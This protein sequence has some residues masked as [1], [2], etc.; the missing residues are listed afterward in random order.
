M[1]R[2]FSLSQAASALS[3][4]AL[5]LCAS[6]AQTDDDLKALVERG[7]FSAAFA[8]AVK[9]AEAGSVYAESTLG[10]LYLTGNGTSKNYDEAQ[11]WLTKAASAGDAK[12]QN[13][14]GIA[15]VDG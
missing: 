5:L 4:F 9:R 14:L 6:C 8:L 2:L 3:L 10:F 7:D 11:K 13:N 12:A 1:S 15:Y